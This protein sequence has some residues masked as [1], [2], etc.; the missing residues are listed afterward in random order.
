MTFLATKQNIVVSTEHRKL[1][2]IGCRG[3][4]GIDPRTASVAKYHIDVVA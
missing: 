2:D 4:E 3:T 1:P